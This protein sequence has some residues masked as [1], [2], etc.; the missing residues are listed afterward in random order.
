MYP[1]RVRD[2]IEDFLNEVSGLLDEVPAERL[3][4]YRFQ[5]FEKLGFIG[6]LNHYG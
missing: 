6:R 3:S 4:P 5:E 1:Y 2:G